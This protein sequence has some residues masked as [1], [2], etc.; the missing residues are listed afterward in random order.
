MATSKFTR[1]LMSNFPSWMKMAKDPDSIGAQFL[2]VFGVTFKDFED[3]MNE[4]VRNFYITTANTELI[5][6]VYKVPLQM[7]RVVDMN[8]ID[9]VD[10]VSIR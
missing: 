5:D 4:A 8:G 3:E 10:E 2:D 7:E 6:W 1:N 9:Q